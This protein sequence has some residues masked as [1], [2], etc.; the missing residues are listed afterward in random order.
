MRERSIVGW[1]EAGRTRGSYCQY[2]GLREMAVYGKYGMAR[3]CD[4]LAEY[5]YD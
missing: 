2:S 5:M 3:R 1:N 4:R